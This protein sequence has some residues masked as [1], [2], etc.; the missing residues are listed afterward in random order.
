MSVYL[1]LA[2]SAFLL[3]A[4]YGTGAIAQ[5]EAPRQTIFIP[6]YDQPAPNRSA[7]TNRRLIRF[8][9]T[10]DFPPLN[11]RGPS[12]ETTGFNVDLARAL[13][14]ILDTA[15]SMQAV[16]WS[17]LELRLSARSGDVAIAGHRVA[18]RAGGLIET[19]PYLANPARF[20]RR[21]G[22]ADR[23]WTTVG[24]LAGS[25]HE[26]YLA[27]FAPDLSLKPFET[28]DAQWAALEGGEVDAIF[29]DAITAA[30][31]LSAGESA[32]CVLS[33]G[34]YTETRYFGEGLTML[35]RSDD[36]DL[37][38]A[39]EAALTRVIDSGTFAELYLRYFPLGLY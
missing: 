6:R 14:D 10:E 33:S 21:A 31:R 26:R 36:R 8:L 19:S 15:C 13:C 32:C 2:I 9:T 1:K 27:T 23:S 35:L 30:A 7:T 24:I 20:V 22:T 38:E 29:T 5:T 28:S 39:L 18:G 25:A 34:A 11:F 37:V 3:V 12:G 16:P 17:Q 4:V